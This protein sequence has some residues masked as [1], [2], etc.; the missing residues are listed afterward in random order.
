MTILTVNG[1]VRDKQNTIAANIVSVLLGN[2]IQPM[3]CVA[4]CL[5]TYTLQRMRYIILRVIKG[6][7]NSNEI[8]EL[9]TFIDALCNVVLRTMWTPV[10]HFILPSA[11]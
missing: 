10:Y 3:S 8:I 11:A 9:I 5:I 1:K 2:M 6:A 7:S 4:C